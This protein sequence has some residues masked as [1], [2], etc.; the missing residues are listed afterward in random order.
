MRDLWLYS[1]IMNAISTI[2]VIWFAV[3]LTHGAGFRCR[4]ALVRL[5][6]RSALVFLAFA[7]LNCALLQIQT[8]AGP[9]P[10]WFMFQ[11]AYSLALLASVFRNLYAPAELP[12]GANWHT[13]V[14]I[15]YHLR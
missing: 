4:L 13:Q 15:R 8:R 11:V 12:E 14:G 2:I 3:R 10:E 1:A 9:S 6:Q 5:V 7:M